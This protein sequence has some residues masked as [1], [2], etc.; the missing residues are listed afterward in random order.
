MIL[1]LGDALKKLH[2]ARFEEARTVSNCWMM[3]ANPHSLIDVANRQRVFTAMPKCWCGLT[4][5]RDHFYL[6]GHSSHH[7]RL[8]SDHLISK[9][10]RWRRKTYLKRIA[11]EKA[12][13]LR[14]ERRVL[15]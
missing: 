15:V 3:I 8:E 9:E 6:P 5:A 14:M 10:Y 11:T 2:L 12:R 4:N 7:H 1:V 13:H